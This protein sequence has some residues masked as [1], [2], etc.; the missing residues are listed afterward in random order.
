MKK[1]VSL[2]KKWKKLIWGSTKLQAHYR[3]WKA[4]CLTMNLLAE[5]EREKKMKQRMLIKKFERKKVE[6]DIE[7]VIERLYGQ[8]MSQRNLTGTR[9]TDTIQ[10]RFEKGLSTAHHI[11]PHADL[12][13]VLKNHKLKHHKKQKHKNKNRSKNTNTNMNT[14]TKQ[15]HSPNIQTFN[16]Y[17]SESCPT[18][19]PASTL[20]SATNQNTNNIRIR[21]LFYIIFFN[22]FYVLYGFRFLLFYDFFVFLGDFL[23]LAESKSFRTIGFREEAEKVKGGTLDAAILNSLE[24]DNFR[25]YKDSEY[26]ESKGS[27][28]H[29]KD[30]HMRRGSTKGRSIKQSLGKGG[31]ENGVEVPEDCLNLLKKLSDEIDGQKRDMSKSGRKK[32]KA[33]YE[34][35][36]ELLL[37]Y[38]S[39][40]TQRNNLTKQLALRK[41]HK[42]KDNRPSSAYGGHHHI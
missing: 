36:M 42:S 2:L 16:D 25:D 21:I 27:C 5:R 39:S 12:L 38:F 1:A 19:H 3:R 14:N 34:K 8:T 18:Y 28:R 13:T 30:G 4:K 20:Q 37:D 41:S 31:G 35:D 22:I 32:L 24:V 40:P 11:I 23:F 9:T 26:E 6:S 17:Y 29:G 33:K 10:P 15:K 7:N